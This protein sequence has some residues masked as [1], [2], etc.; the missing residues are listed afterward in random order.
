MRVSALILTAS[1][2]VCTSIIG[3]S[4][5]SAGDG[6]SSVD[7]GAE[8]GTDASPSDAG[9]AP[10][11]PDA[12]A[13]TDTALDAGA[14]PSPFVVVTINGG[15]SPG[16]RHDDDEAPDL[17]PYTAETS[18]IVD[19]F[20]QNSLSWNPAEAALA[21]WLAT[22]APDIAVFQEIFHD[23][24]CQDIDRPEDEP[25][26]LVC[27]GY[28][29]QRPLQV[30]RLLGDEY[31][32]AC[33]ARKPDICIAVRASFGTIVG[34]DSPGCVIEWDGAV[35][36]SGC[37]SRDRIGRVLVTR[38]DGSSINIIGWHG[39]SGALPEDAAC[40][41]DQLRLVFEDAGAGEPLLR[42]EMPNLLAGD[43]NFDP[44]LF[45][46]DDVDYLADRVGPGR[47][48]RW[49]S[50]TALDGPRSYGGG[51]SIDHMISDALQGD[52]VI[53]GSSDGVPPVWDR[54]Y[55]DHRPVV[56]TLF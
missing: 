4:S 51:A 53:P 30:Q 11:A 22:T 45:V 5:D 1:C 7:T 21:G 2:L 29:P 9:A 16:R 48:F 3:C 24:W 28:T 39:T 56:C 12:P 50:P 38:P 13:D 18:S 35:P 54:V 19:E 49:L 43:F 37:T 42:P 36:L 47:A 23:P 20:Y 55:W 15:T 14:A 27:N 32:F 26:D 6:L 46:G 31:Q 25:L 8:A 34:C 33:G 17:P 40:R 52:C 44:E 10:L 41:A